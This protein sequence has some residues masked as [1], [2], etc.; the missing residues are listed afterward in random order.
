MRFVL[1]VSLIS[2]DRAEYSASLTVEVPHCKF[3]NTIDFS[4][5]SIDKTDNIDEPCYNIIMEIPT[6]FK[7]HVMQITCRLDNVHTHCIIYKMRSFKAPQDTFT[8]H[9]EDPVRTISQKHNQQEISS[10]ISGLDPAFNF[11]SWSNAWLKNGDTLH[12]RFFC[13]SR[14][15]KG[16]RRNALLTSTLSNNLQS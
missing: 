9:R 4:I 13:D 5:V 16:I 14:V 11:R 2:H 1:P 15:H 8:K 10:E 12:H 3:S 6:R 7:P